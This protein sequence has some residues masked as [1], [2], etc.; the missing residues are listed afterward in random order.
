METGCRDAI[1]GAIEMRARM[2]TLNHRLSG[3][4]AAPVQI[5][6]GIHCGE[7]I[8]GSMGPPRSPNFSAIGDNI[9]IAA[10]LEAQTKVYECGLVVSADVARAAGIDLSFYP[11]HAADIR[12][13]EEPVMVYAIPEPQELERI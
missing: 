13:R 3:E 2:E 9:N 8:V 12:G 1:N 5:G 10:R 6:I 7:A 11:M 4:L